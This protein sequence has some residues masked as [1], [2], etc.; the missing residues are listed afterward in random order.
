MQWFLHQEP[1]LPQLQSNTLLGSVLGLPPTR[2]RLV[3]AYPF[4]GDKLFGDSLEKILVETR[5]KKKAMPRSLCQGDKRPFN[6]QPFTSQHT[7]PRFHNDNKT[8][9]WGTNR[10]SFRKPRFI[11]KFSKANTNRADNGD[12]VSKGYKA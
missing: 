1:W 5:D 11:P 9:R 2:T 4:Q 7:L 6:S 10:Q 8:S 3:T 12:R